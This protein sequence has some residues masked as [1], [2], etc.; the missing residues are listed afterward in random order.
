MNARAL[1]GAVAVA[2]IAGVAHAQGPPPEGM[3]PGA[4]REEVLS[5]SAHDDLELSPDLNRWHPFNR[6][7]Y[8]GARIMQVHHADGARVE[9]PDC[10]L[11]MRACELEGLVAL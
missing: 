3:P 1:A 11:P 10:D 2:L 8:F 5:K 6:Q 9:G 7:M 4:A